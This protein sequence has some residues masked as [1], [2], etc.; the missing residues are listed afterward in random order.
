[1]EWGFITS[2]DCVKNLIKSGKMGLGGGGGRRGGGRKK[3]REGRR[4]R[5][6]GRRLRRRRS[7]Y[8]R[9]DNLLPLFKMVFEH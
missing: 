5:R 6:L 1:M 9:G 4:L 3:G 2:F 8:G 7:R